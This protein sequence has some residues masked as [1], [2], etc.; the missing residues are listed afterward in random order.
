[1]NL[2][3]DAAWDDHNHWEA[4]WWGNCVNTFAEETKQMTYASR[5]GLQNISDGAHW[6]YYNLEGKSILDIGGGPTSLLL[7]CHSGGRQV[8]VDPCSY[9]EW[10]RARYEAAGIEYIVELGEYLNYLKAII[11]R[12][13]FDEAWIYNVLQHT[14][15]PAEIIHHART[16][17]KAVRIFEWVEIPA[18]PGHPQ[19]LKPGLLSEWLGGFGSVEDFRPRP[20][21]GCDQVAFYGLFPGY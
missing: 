20:E 13:R 17:A 4:E 3:G 11:E 16:F 5:M 19:E 9:P 21:N 18:H 6:P 1:M 2:T 7:K 12:D 10:V 14:D 15:D 8:V